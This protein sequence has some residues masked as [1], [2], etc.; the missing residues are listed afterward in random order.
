[1]GFQKALIVA[2]LTAPLALGGC[3]TTKSVDEAK[4]MAQR[5]QS[6]A[7]QALAAAKA[8]NDKADAANEKADRMYNRS[9]KK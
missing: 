3:A 7:D 2:L 9:L 8:A 6:T 4:A 5:A 1:M